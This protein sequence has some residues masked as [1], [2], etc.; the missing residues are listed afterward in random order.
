MDLDAMRLLQ[1]IPD[2]LK[3]Q[4][5]EWVRTE[6][7]AVKRLSTT[8]YKAVYARPFERGIDPNDAAHHHKGSWLVRVSTNQVRSASWGEAHTQAV[9][10][11]R[12]ADVQRQDRDQQ[13]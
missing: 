10:L 12:E 2:D 6:S 13:L 8:W 4:G 11:M 9:M 5:W 1:D 7:R 3:M